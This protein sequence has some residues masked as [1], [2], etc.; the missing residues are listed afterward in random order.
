MTGYDL[1]TTMTFDGEGSLHNSDMCCGMIVTQ[2]IITYFFCN[3]R[4]KKIM[5]KSAVTKY[6]FAK[7]ICILFR[8]D[9]IFKK[10]RIIAYI[11][12]DYKAKCTYKSALQIMSL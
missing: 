1:Y 11:I 12:K 3:K 7:I 2:D 5:N 8:L 9:N 10:L 4:R 6:A